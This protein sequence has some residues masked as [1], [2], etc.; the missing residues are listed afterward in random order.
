MQAQREAQGGAQ[1]RG[2]RGGG[3][4][5]E[6]R[7]RRARRGDDEETAVA[8]VVIATKAPARHVLSSCIAL[9]ASSLPVPLSPISSTL[10]S[11]GATFSIISNTAFMAAET[12]YKRPKR[13]CGAARRA[14]RSGGCTAYIRTFA[15]ASSQRGWKSSGGWQA[16]IAVLAGIIV[17]KQELAG[18]LVCCPASGQHHAKENV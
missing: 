10:A 17:T 14:A 4:G 1:S 9:A 3:G 11:L 12:P 2:G 15:N 7:A 6:V 13:A 16:S 18:V 8:L 5:A